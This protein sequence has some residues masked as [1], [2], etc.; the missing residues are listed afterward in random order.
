VINVA[1]Q[2]SGD[3]ERRNEV[4]GIVF[5]KARLLMASTSNL[6][7]ET[8]PQPQR[9]SAR[10]HGNGEGT[11]R[12]RSDGRWEAR[13]HLPGGKRRSFYGETR[14]EVARRIA[15]AR[16]D[17]DKGL[18]IVGEKQAVGQFLAS[19]LEMV[20]PTIRPSTW[21]RYRE[22]LLLHVVPALGKVP[23]SRLTAQHIQVLYAAKLEVGLSPTTVHHLG[24][25][26]HGALARAERLGLVARNVC[27]FVDVPRM[28]DR[29]MHVL[30]PEQVR[31]L[32][33]AVQEDRLEALY[34]LAVTT[35]MRQAELLALR[36][37]DV[38]LGRGTLSVRA[39]LQRAKRD[40]YTFAP[41]K[42]KHS[43]RQI[44][45][46]QLAIAA[47]RRH[48]TRQDIERLASPM[49]EDHDLVFSNTVGKPMDG[50]N[51]LHYHFQPL[52]KRTGLPRIRFHDLRHTAAT[53]LLGRGVNPKIVSEMLGHA[54]IGITLDIYSHVLP[55]MQQ[56]AAAQ[57]DA[58]LGR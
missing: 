49:W 4:E 52:L 13:L 28:A 56:S 18:P 10:R 22:L 48:R 17:R 36:W 12:Q 43:Q 57:M 16:R 47:L 6:T 50:M 11:I 31:T 40:G 45:L 33:D 35:G 25:V 37:R 8:T 2:R 5:R 23:L 7:P 42:T 30:T 38:D 32:L 44:T 34:V 24:T 9:R 21:R 51:L 26:L 53:L 3:R 41:P 46:T 1:V 29:E 39:T 55:T 14:Q 27:D 58:A 20:K 54:S 15:E 19:W